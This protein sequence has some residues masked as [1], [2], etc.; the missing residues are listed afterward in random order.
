MTSLR[1]SIIAYIYNQNFVQIASEP[2]ITILADCSSSHRTTW[3]DK[4]YREQ[5][6]QY[7]HLKALQRSSCTVGFG[8]SDHPVVT[9]EI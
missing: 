2:Q 5:S 9:E 3:L 7:A 8:V 6:L 1:D 4:S